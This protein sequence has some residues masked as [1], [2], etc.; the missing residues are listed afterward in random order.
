MTGQVVS[1]ET[2]IETKYRED[3]RGNFGYDGFGRGFNSPRLHQTFSASQVSVAALA[4]TVTHRSI[5]PFRLGLIQ[6]LIRTL[7]GEVKVVLTTI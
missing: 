3:A 1:T 4:T 2:G 5:P 6:R 7:D